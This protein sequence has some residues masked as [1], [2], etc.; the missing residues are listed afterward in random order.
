VPGWLNGFTLWN[1]LILALMLLS[2]G[3]PIVQFFLMKTYDPTAWGY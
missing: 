3:Y 2:Y 1:V